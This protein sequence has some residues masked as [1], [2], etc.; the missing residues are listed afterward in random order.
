MRCGCG[1][2]RPRGRGSGSWR[3]RR[4]V[5]W[6]RAPASDGSTLVVLML[7]GER[8]LSLVDGALDASRDTIGTAGRLT[9]TLPAAVTQ[10]LLTRVPAAFHCGIQHVLLT[11]L[12]LA[13]AQ[14]CGRRGR[15]AST[16]VLVDVEGHGREEVSADI[17]LSRTVGWFTSLYPVR[18]DVGGVGG[19]EGC[20]GGAAVGRAVELL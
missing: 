4:L 10:G 7:R 15:G 16:A 1:W 14:W 5:R 19:E 13:V 3:W 11:G 20:G 18:L 6:M 8:S 2:K 17:D 9:L 12:A